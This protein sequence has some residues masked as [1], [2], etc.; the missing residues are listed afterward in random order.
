MQAKFFL[1]CYK[2]QAIE[3]AYTILTKYPIAS[4]HP[5]LYSVNKQSEFFKPKILS[6]ED[7]ENSC[8]SNNDWP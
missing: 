2:N 8:D 3:E 1:S 6:N 7:I 5:A 4:P